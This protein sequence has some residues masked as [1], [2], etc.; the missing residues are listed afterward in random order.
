ME[1]QLQTADPG[2]TVTTISRAMGYRYA[3]SF[4]ARPMSEGAF[5]Q[6]LEQIWVKGS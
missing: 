6:S 1:K 5:R 2:D 3:S 4:T